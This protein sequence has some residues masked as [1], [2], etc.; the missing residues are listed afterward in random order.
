M[1]TSLY[2]N[3]SYRREET[4]AVQIIL[5]QLVLLLGVYLFFKAEM[6]QPSNKHSSLNNN[7]STVEASAQPYSS[8]NIVD[9]AWSCQPTVLANGE[10]GCAK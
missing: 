8:R 4:M 1:E 3:D 10:Y 2:I 6:F 7:N 5:M 9:I